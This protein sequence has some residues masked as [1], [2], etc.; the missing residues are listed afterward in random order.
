MGAILAVSDEAV[1]ETRAVEAERCL[2]MLLSYS[3]VSLDAPLGHLSLLPFCWLVFSAVDARPPQLPPLK[4]AC[5]L[6]TRAVKPFLAFQEGQ[7]G[8]AHL[9][10]CRKRFG[11]VSAGS[12]GDPPP[13]TSP[14]AEP[15][16]KSHIAFRAPAPTL[17][18]VKL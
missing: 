8:I 11:A 16:K 4:A 15:F 18:Y 7:H 6:A 13:S 3:F 5:P 9:G 2:P 12:E 17:W 1:R 10:T 14:S